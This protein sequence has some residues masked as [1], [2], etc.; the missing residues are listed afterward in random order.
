MLHVSRGKLRAALEELS[1]AERTQSLMIGEH[2]LSAQV[3]GWAISTKAR[4]GMLDDARA[5]LA[6]V[7]A[8]RA[9]SGEICNAYA[10]LHLTEGNPASALT[11]LGP[12]LEG[13][14]P[15]IYAFTLVEAHLLAARAHVE[16]GD[17]RGAHA[18]IERALALAE[19][20]RLIFP[21]VMTG[22]G[23][24]LEALPR[25][26]TAHGALFI[27]ILDVLRGASI[28]KDRP[29]L[30]T[31]QELTPTEL[32]VLRFLPT[33]MT[34]TEIARELYLSVNTVNTQVRNI[35]AKLDARDRST[36]VEHARELRL[37]ASSSVAH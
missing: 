32:R 24:L 28:A 12:V 27:D 33:N 31:A 29:V 6:A 15:V 2:A 7:A 5:S 1:A 36:A 34:R 30:P 9:R 4:F 16:L 25:H 35:Y 17:R 10:V 37:I 21:F 13:H 11:A 3:S 8:E 26:E 22:S 20:D 23:D 14:A 19:P 18:A